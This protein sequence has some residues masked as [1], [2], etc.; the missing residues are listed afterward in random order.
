MKVQ[1]SFPKPFQYS[2]WTHYSQCNTSEAAFGWKVHFD[3]CACW[4]CRNPYFDWFGE[5]EGECVELSSAGE[6]HWL[7][8]MSRAVMEGQE[9]V[10]IETWVWAPVNQQQTLFWQWADGVAS[11]IQT[12]CHILNME[13]DW[14]CLVVIFLLPCKG[15]DSTPP[16]PPP[17]PHWPYLWGL[18]AMGLSELMSE[19]SSC[20]KDARAC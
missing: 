2:R 13:L 3:Y 10:C 1:S 18:A 17:H 5:A 6:W 14:Q 8:R 20:N 12:S 9:C 16:P 4:R 19:G 11:A 15:C 7:N